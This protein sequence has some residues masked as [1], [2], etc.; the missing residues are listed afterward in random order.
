MATFEQKLKCLLW[1]SEGNCGQTVREKWS[2]TYQG[3]PPTDLMLTQWKQSLEE[4]REDTRVR[5]PPQPQKLDQQQLQQPSAFLTECAAGSGAVAA[6]DSGVDGSSG[7]DSGSGNSGGISS[8]SGGGGGDDGFKF[9]LKT[10]LEDIRHKQ[11][12]FCVER[13]WN[14]YHS[15]RNVL[16]ALVGEVGEL[17]EIFQWKGEVKEG[18]ADFTAREKEHVGEELSDVLIYLV[19]LADRCQVDLSS[20]VWSKFQKNCQKY[21]AKKVFGLSHKYTEYEIIKD[22]IK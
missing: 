7:I 12:E 1:L 2:Q 13:N 3:D 4:P 20:A 22:S 21:P 19:R 6:G 14:Q 11:E 10:S 5:F 16:L 9:S 15:P 17:A 8:S 18:L